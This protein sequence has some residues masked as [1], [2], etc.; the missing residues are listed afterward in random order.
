MQ[1][2][3]YSAVE[4]LRD[5]SRI[6]IRALKPTD[7]DEL[8]GTMS[9]MSDESIRRRFFAPKR[10]FTE[11]EI[12]YYLNVDFVDHVALVAVL[13]AD[14]QTPIV[15]GCRYI[16]TEPGVAEIAF[17][18]D[19]Q[20]QGRGIGGL[21]MKHLAAIARESGLREL[22]AEVLPSNSPMLAVFE[23]AALE[24]TTRRVGDVVHVTLR[25]A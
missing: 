12:D 11:R 4:A 23:K 5:G 8:L 14:G 18:V 15:G 22:T 13:N 24:T 21:L 17:A 2:A 1:A 7:R 10:H 20:H 3:A 6:G 16:V 25:L 19:D 9:R